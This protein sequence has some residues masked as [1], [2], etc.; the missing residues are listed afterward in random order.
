[1]PARRLQT[2]LIFVDGLPGTGKSTMA[3]LLFL[4]LKR[5]GYE[6]AWFHEEEQP[7]PLHQPPE[8]MSQKPLSLEDGL[9]KW[10]DLAD[11]LVGKGRTLLLDASIF[12]NTIGWLLAMGYDKAQMNAY[13]QKRREVLAALNP[14]LIYLRHERVKDDMLHLFQER[15]GEWEQLMTERI[16]ATPYGAT[17]SH[18]LNGLLHYYRHLQKI[19]DHLYRSWPWL[20]CSLLAGQWAEGQRQ[21]TE[22]L[23]LP[24]FKEVFA[25]PE[26]TEQWVGSY[27]EIRD[28]F[29]W[30]LAYDADGFYIDDASKTFLRYKDGQTYYASGSCIQLTFARDKNSG[31][32]TMTCGGN[33]L[34]GKVLAL[35]GRRLIRRDCR[36]DDVSNGLMN[37]A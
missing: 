37:D 22:C 32:I 24:P 28:G 2:P 23:A 9:K 12:Q 19:T 4:H 34:A 30:H 31:A 15:G 33:T 36:S 25:L 13:D 29:A 16:S 10:Q 18:D 20:K 14:M 3:Q 11:G 8:A 17:I 26:A 6:A 1:M 5:L 27:R 21:I 7:H 35:S